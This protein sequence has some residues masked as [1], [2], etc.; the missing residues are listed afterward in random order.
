MT[1]L[2]RTFRDAERMQVADLWPEIVDRTPSQLPPTSSGRRAMTIAVAAIIAVAGVGFMIRA[3]TRAE[4][5]IPATPTIFR[6]DQEFIV[7]APSTTGSGWD[8]A[9]QDPETGKV[10]TIAK[11]DGLVDCAKEAC[12]NFIRK[13]EWSADGRWVAFEVSN[14]SLD[15]PPLGP[16]GSTIGVWV[17]GPTGEPQQLTTPCDAPPSGSN[18]PVEQLWEWSPVGTRLAY[19]RIDGKNDELFVI[20][21]SDGS[22]T[23]LVR[24]NIDPPYPAQASSLAWSPDGS[25]IAYVDRSSVY[26]VDVEGDERSLLA[27]SFEDIIHIAWSPDG[28]RILV[29]DQTRYRIQVMDADGSDL[30]VLLQGE[31][32]C[33]EPTWS[34]NGDRILYVLSVVRPGRPAPEKF[35]SVV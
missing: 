32:S 20:D 15:G 13:A 26:A 28:R 34:P 24:G 23:S 17:Q 7:F 18:V 25:R 22:R 3:F 14:A 4:R 6:E 27:D 2:D 31:D 21:P 35:G 5:S 9:A 33:C 10:R 12:A 29:Q 8:L 11:T 16:C 30:H 1:D 19:A